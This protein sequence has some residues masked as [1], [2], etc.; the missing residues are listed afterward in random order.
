MVGPAPG[1]AGGSEE[2]AASP[3][4]RATAPWSARGGRPSEGAD[5]PEPPEQQKDEHQLTVTGAVGLMVPR[6]AATP[7]PLLP[8]GRIQPLGVRCQARRPPRWLG[9]GER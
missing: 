2:R 8:T 7:L 5:N 6:R 4:P 9:P 1:G 3:R